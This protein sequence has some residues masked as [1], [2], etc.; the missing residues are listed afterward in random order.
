MRVIGVSAT[1]SSTCCCCLG[2]SVCLPA[3]ACLARVGRRSVPSPRRADRSLPTPTGASRVAASPRARLVLDLQLPSAGCC[4][5]TVY[6]RVSCGQSR[7]RG[8]GERRRRRTGGGRGERWYGCT[9][10][11]VAC[12]W[13]VCSRVSPLQQVRP[14]V[15]LAAEARSWRDRRPQQRGEKGRHYTRRRTQHTDAI[16]CAD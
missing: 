9:P 15:Q 3:A 2:L 1:V 6:A 10:F 14:R 7:G 8:G 16:C 5:P 4:S 12:S 13:S 11:Y